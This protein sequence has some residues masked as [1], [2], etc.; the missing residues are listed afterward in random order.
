MA[1]KAAAYDTKLGYTAADDRQLAGILAQAGVS[2]STALLVSAGSGFA[3]SVAAGLALVQNSYQ[4]Q[5]GL[6]T[7]RNDAAVNAMHP[8]PDPANPRID[9]VYVKVYDSADGGDSSD[10]VQALVLAG[11][12]TAGATLSNLNGMASFTGINNYLL[13]SRVLVPAGAASAASFTYADARVLTAPAAGFAS[14]LPGYEFGYDQITAN[15]T[16]TSSNPAAADTIISCAAHTFDGSPVLAEFWTP[17]IQ[18]PLSSDLTIALYEGG[19]QLTWLFQAQGA[20]GAIPTVFPGGGQYKFTPTAGSHTYTV[21]GFWAGSGN[22]RINAG[23][24]GS[25]NSP[26]A[27]IR[28]TKV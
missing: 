15:V 24:G 16:V 27:F 6:Y 12:P 20:A 11:T 10:V 19:T 18:P 5:G 7:V 23:A 25:G 1:F 9:Q 26:P 13:L 2:N 8:N 4:A 3:S 28:F 14:K 17:G 22:G 21:G